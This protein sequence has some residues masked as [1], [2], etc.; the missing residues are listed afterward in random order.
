[1]VLTV[2]ARGMARL[3]QELEMTAGGELD[4]G[5]L[6]LD[7]GVILAGRVTDESGTPIAG[8]EIRSE[9]D[10]DVGWRI[11]GLSRHPLVAETD[12]AGRFEIFDQPVGPWVLLAGHPDLQDL[13]LIHI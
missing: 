2:R 12:S 11:R 9:P 3:R 7:F 10:R 5:D 4:L 8:A 1:M 13:S 6:L